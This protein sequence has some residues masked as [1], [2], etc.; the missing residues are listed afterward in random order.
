[1]KYAQLIKEITKQKQQPVITDITIN[2]HLTERLAARVVLA[3]LL[4]ATPIKRLLTTAA[5][6][7][8]NTRCRTI[9]WASAAQHHCQRIG[10]AGRTV[11]AVNF[12]SITRPRGAA[13]TQSHNAQRHTC[14]HAYT[15]MYKLPHWPLKCVQ[16]HL[17]VCMHVCMCIG[18]L[19]LILLVCM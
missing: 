11:G 10:S 7:H 14:L 6:R 3:W 12:N 17:F 8:L 1:M 18:D 2:R 15:C 9:N 13:A 5:A 16:L 4:F 19:N